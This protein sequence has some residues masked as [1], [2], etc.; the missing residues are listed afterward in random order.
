[1]EWSNGRTTSFEDARCR[2]ES[3][4]HNKHSSRV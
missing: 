1:V 3:Y 4:F 2:F